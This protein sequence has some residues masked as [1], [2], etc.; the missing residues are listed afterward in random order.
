MGRKAL[1]LDYR[2]WLTSLTSRTRFAGRAWLKPRGRLGEL[3][4]RINL[5]IRAKILLAMAI[6]IFMMVAINAVLMVQM[7]DYSRQYDAIISNITTANSI[8]G[9][10][11]PAI[12]SEMWN[13][14]AGKSEFKDGRAYAIITD[15]DNRLRQM[16]SNA[17]SAEAK[18]RVEIIM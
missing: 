6:V 1:M 4:T 16:M 15:V 18:I 3:L 12:D 8:N 17:A 9:Y 10:I 7:T 11:K 5:S 2:Q 13:I 14:V